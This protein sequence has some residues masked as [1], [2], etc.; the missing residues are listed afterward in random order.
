[1]IDVTYRAEAKVWS[2]DKS[3][4]TIQSTEW[5]W[6]YLDI[7]N[8]RE[9]KSVEIVDSHACTNGR[10]NEG[11]GKLMTDITV[12]LRFCFPIYSHEDWNIPDMM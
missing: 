8:G 5:K 9:A 10:E 12:K 7:E 4:E 6:M 2:E 3:K 1:M 11:E